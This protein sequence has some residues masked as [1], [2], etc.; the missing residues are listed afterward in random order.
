M[1]MPHENPT[2][3]RSNRLQAEVLAGVLDLLPRQLAILDQDGT[4]I[5]VNRAWRDFAAEN[6]GSA[7]AIGEGADY[8]AVCEAAARAGDALAAHF[9][10]GL[11]GVL[12]GIQ[13]NF[14]HRYPCHSATEDRWFVA[15]VY[16]L[17]GEDRDWVVVAHEPAGP[18]GDPGADEND[19]DRDAAPEIERL[20]TVFSA[21][22]G[23]AARIYDTGPMREA[24]PGLFRE[25]VER[26][27]ALL[28]LRLERRAYKVRRSE[29]PLADIAATLGRHGAGPRDVVEVYRA[30]LERRTN[31]GASRRTHAYLEEGRLLV[32]E[33][34][35]DLAAF[36]RTQRFVPPPR[37]S[38]S[39]AS[40]VPPRDQPT[41]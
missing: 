33:L 17:P 10:R 34:M 24:N 22:A 25:L 16:R 19:L 18:D 27:A 20:Q 14:S 6:G 15:H 7:C 26:I 35:G 30:A 40:A 2:T 8:L 9:A 39:S 32:L 21:P 28:D 41:A 11:Q 12:R 5:F 37:A 36:Y 38:Q 23:I 31:R 29:P 4:I 13:A 3:A 1:A